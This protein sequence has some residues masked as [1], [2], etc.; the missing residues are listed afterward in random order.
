MSA[1]EQRGSPLSS[2]CECKGRSQR[3]PGTAPGSRAAGAAIGPATSCGSRLSRAFRS[4]RRDEALPVVLAM[5]W[6]AAGAGAGEG[7]GEGLGDHDVPGGAPS[8]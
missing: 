8:T 5:G 7:E 2:T 1:V 3:A 4:A 6:G